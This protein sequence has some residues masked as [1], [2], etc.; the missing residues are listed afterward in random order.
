[1]GDASSSGEGPFSGAQ[2]AQAAAEPRASPIDRCGRWVVRAGAEQAPPLAEGSSPWWASGD[3]RRG[4]HLCPLA[5][6]RS[7]VPVGEVGRRVPEARADR[8]A[9]ADAD[10]AVFGNAFG[11]LGPAAKAANGQGLSIATHL[12]CKR[13]LSGKERR[14]KP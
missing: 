2:F 14:D 1:M 12:P 7:A 10:G 11:L 13:G 3:R 9:L 5:C 6:S 8:E 4:D